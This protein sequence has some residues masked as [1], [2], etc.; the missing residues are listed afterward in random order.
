MKTVTNYFLVSGLLFLL[1]LCT[2]IFSSNSVLALV[3]RFFFTL[4]NR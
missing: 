3:I 4:E 2:R 1:Y